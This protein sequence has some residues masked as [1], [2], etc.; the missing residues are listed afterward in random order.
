MKFLTLLIFCISMMPS[1]RAQDNKVRNVAIFVH[2]GVQLLDFAGPGEVFAAAGSGYKVYTVASSKDLVLSDRF[3]SIKPQYTLEDCPKPD[4]IVFPG[5]ATEIP[6]R[7]EKV[8]Q[9]VKSAGKDSEYLLSVCTGVFLLA[10]GGFL[11][12]KTATTHY[13]CQDGLANDYPKINVVKGKRFIDNGHII[14]TEGIS[15]GIDGSLYLISK[16]SG[17]EHADKIAKYIMYN[18]ALDQLDY[19]VVAN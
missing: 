10:K 4:I 6:L 8:I 12:G 18:W 15:A 1:C 13:C 16:I 2:E 7:D 17:K 5:G 9:W 14:T 11:D 3:V 19:T